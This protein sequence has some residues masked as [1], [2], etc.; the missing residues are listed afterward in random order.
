MEEAE[1]SKLPSKALKD[2]NKKN[3]ED[4]VEVADSSYAR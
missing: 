4:K 3:A 2:I 1:E